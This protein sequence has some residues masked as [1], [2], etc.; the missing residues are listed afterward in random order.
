MKTENITE[1]VKKV[2]IWVSAYVNFSAFL[3][4]I[5]KYIAL[6]FAGVIAGLVY[7]MKQIKP[8]QNISTDE[9]INE[10]SRDLRIGKIKQHGQNLSMNNDLANE[11][12]P[13]TA[14]EIRQRKLAARRKARE[15]AEL[16]AETEKEESEQKNY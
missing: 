10:Q 11:E 2:G 16:Q 13:V 7:A 4:Q 14:R 5:W 9:F 6:I 3:K 1:K 15:E 12:T 8:V